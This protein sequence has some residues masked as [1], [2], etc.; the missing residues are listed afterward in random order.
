MGK[1]PVLFHHDKTLHVDN[2]KFPDQS[3]DKDF[4]L[5]N[6]ISEKKSSINLPSFTTY[7]HLIHFLKNSNL[8][9]AKWLS[10]QR[11]LGPSLMSRSQALRSTQWKKKTSSQKCSSGLHTWP[12]AQSYTHIKQANVFKPIPVQLQALSQQQCTVSCVCFMLPPVSVPQSMKKKELLH[13]LSIQHREGF[14]EKFGK[15]VQARVIAGQTKM[16]CYLL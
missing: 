9:L 5:L 2:M 16:Q 10:R 13:F 14:L 4:Q 15:K 6:I 12:V 11:H 8:R 7:K 3:M 1:A